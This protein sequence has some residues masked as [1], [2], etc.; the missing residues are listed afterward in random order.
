MSWNQARAYCTAVG[1]RLPLEDEWEYV[2][3]AGN[4]SSRY[5]A[6]GQIGWYDANSGSRTHDVGAKLPNAFGLSDMLGNVWEWVED[7]YDAKRYTKRP[8][9]DR[10]S[11]AREGWNGV[12]RGGS[13][14]VVS[15]VA[16]ASVRRS[17][18]ARTVDK[19]FGFRCAG[20]F[21]VP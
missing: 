5:D 16:R 8:N 20:D 19:S 17:V 12:L 11:E 9:P 21:P 1:G 13:W 7:R 15:S 4:P 14:D 2:A 3:R 10:V 18:D 6:L